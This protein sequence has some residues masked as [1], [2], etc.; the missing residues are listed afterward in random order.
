MNSPDGIITK[1]FTEEYDS[2][3]NGDN[4]RYIMNSPDSKVTKLL[5]EEYGGLWWL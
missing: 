3:G 4:A 1:L 5:T 2:G